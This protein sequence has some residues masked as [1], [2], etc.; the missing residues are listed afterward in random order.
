MSKL[1]YGYRFDENYDDWQVRGDVHSMG[2]ELIR[3]SD[4]SRYDPIPRSILVALS[5]SIHCLEKLTAEL[6]R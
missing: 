3:F 5:S 6:L 4:V 1:Q 2:T